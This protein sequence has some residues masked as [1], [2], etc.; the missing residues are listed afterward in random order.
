MNYGLVPFGK[1][2]GNFK[3]TM[4]C[5]GAAIRGASGPTLVRRTI[6]TYGGLKDEDRIFTNLYLDGSPLLDGA[7]KRVSTQFDLSCS[8]HHTN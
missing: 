8:L 4:L 7:L 2:T 1:S 5:K 3:A 6:R